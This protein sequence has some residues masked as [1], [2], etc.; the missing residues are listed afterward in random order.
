ML[1]GLFFDPEDEE[2]IFLK[3]GWLPFMELYHKRENSTNLYLLMQCL[4]NKFIVQQYNTIWLKGQHAGL[5][6][7]RSHDQ[8]LVV[9]AYFLFV[10]FVKMI[11]NTEFALMLMIYLC[12]RF[13]CL[14]PVVH[15][16]LPLN[17][18]L[19]AEFMQPPFSYFTFHKN[20]ILEKAANSHTPIQCPLSN[21]ASLGQ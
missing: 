4:R 19:N 5:V 20:I 21:A 1:F 17:W 18:K 6:H 16:L 10:K 9:P 8:I 3:H 14:D 7:R 12:T 15:Q 13:T 11:S 2:S